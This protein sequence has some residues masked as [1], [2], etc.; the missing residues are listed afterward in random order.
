LTLLSLVTSAFLLSSY[1]LSLRTTMITGFS[2]SPGGLL[3]PYSLGVLDSLQYNGFLDRK[4]PIAGS[5]AGA[6]ATASHACNL[7]SRLILDATIRMSDRCMEL[8]GARGRLLPLLRA[9]LETFIQDEQFEALQER[10]GETVIAFQEVLP[11]NRPIHQTVFK[12]RNDLT[13]AV[14]YS[15]HFP[16]FTSNSPAAIDTS[17]RFP[18]IVVDGFFTVP[19]SRFGCPDFELAN[20]H[21][22]RTVGISAFPKEAF[23]IDAFA[24]E[25]FI[26]PTLEDED[27]NQVQN[28]LRLATQASSAKELTQL[29]E[30][31]WADA[32]RWCRAQSSDTSIDAAD[33]ALQ[34]D[35]NV[36]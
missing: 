30:S 18:R 14:C 16:F 31:G 29:F 15:S 9:E 33:E 27:G 21:V 28:L 11:F 1:P 24:S 34:R 7:D 10:E 23:G 12:D 19:R 5:S 2:L 8:G 6:I 36:G 4:T 32:E 20:V 26:S 3:L 25:D 17:G 35:K 13:N 22:D